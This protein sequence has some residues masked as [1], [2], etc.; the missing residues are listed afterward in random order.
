[1]SQVTY[2][3]ALGGGAVTNTV[4]KPKRPSL[5]GDAKWLG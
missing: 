2:Q 5:V 4:P 1:M 3:V